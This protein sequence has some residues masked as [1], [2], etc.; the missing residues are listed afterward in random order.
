MFLYEKKLSETG[1]S[2]TSYASSTLEKVVFFYSNV[3]ET[4]VKECYHNLRSYYPF[5]ACL[6]CSIDSLTDRN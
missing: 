4:I 1:S 2:K 3:Y 6:T 5:L